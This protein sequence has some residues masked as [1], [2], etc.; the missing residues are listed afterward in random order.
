MKSKCRHGVSGEDCGFTHPACNPGQNKNMESRKKHENVPEEQKHKKV[1]SA[2][3]L[4]HCTFYLKNKCRF[5]VSGKGCGFTHPKRCNKFMDLGRYGCKS[6][7]I[8]KKFHPRVCN[9]SYRHMQCT[10]KKCDWLHIRKTR[11]PLEHQ[12]DVYRYCSQQTRKH[13]SE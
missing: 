12:Q 10:K 4:E 6:D 11:K 7:D 13:K 8:C 9:D 1:P 2:K 3:S 5:G